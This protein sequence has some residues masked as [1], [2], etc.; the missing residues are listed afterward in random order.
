MGN[1]WRIRRKANFSLWPIWTQSPRCRFTAMGPNWISYG[2]DGFQKGPIATLAPRISAQ[3]R[4][5]IERWKK[6]EATREQAE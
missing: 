2:S 4:G 5:V 3:V 1:Y 6:I